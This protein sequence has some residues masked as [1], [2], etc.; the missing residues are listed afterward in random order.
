MDQC[1]LLSNFFFWKASLNQKGI[2]V[3]KGKRS[4]EK[5]RE[6]RKKGKHK[7]KK[8]KGKLNMIVK[9]SSI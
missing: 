9:V 2:K 7:K 8:E 3:E 4:K 6:K 5:G 1:L